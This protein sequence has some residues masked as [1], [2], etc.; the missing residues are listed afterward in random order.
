[1]TNYIVNENQLIGLLYKYDGFNFAPE[2]VKK[3]LKSKKP[4]ELV[5]GGE[6][7]IT[8]E[9]G[10]GGIETMNGVFLGNEEEN[11]NIGLNE[12]LTENQAIKLEGKN[13][14]I[15]IQEVR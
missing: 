11:K 4:V 1:M 10:V 6:V 15:Y 9:T 5:V 3:F 13:I 7:Y 8:T 14:K 12:L 2:I